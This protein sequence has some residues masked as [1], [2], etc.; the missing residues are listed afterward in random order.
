MTTTRRFFLLA[1][2]APLWTTRVVAQSGVFP[3]PG[4]PIRL[5]VPAPPGG[6]GDV[7]ARALAL[8]L[9]GSLKTTVLVENKPG[10]ASIP[11]A[12]EVMRA[13]PDGHTLL[14][15][16]NTTHTQVPH[17]FAKAPFDPFADFTPIA[18]LYRGNSVLVAHP[19]FPANSLPEAIALSRTQPV[20]F[21]SP[22]AGTTGHLLIEVLNADYGARFVHVPYKG[23]APAGQDL[24][25]G[26]VQLLF[27]SPATSYPHVKA[28]KLKAIAVTGDKRL[29]A[30]PD[31]R[32]TQEQ[33]LPGLETGTWMGLFGPARL[34]VSIVERLNQE[35]VKAVAAS[36]LREQFA[37]LGLELVSTSPQDFAEL[38]RRDHERWGV[39]IRRIGLKLD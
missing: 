7:V 39:L 19:S 10:G 38:I 15:T 16:L 13:A 14:V 6:P 25:A 20:A 9:T 27:D 31:V 11:G 29:P 34:P 4:R 23:A 35:V 24:V 8:E 22:S 32:S 17:L 12:L 30:F 3:E 18:Q 2:L 36:R 21:A 26:H 1:A 37:A 5:V 28:G 33:G